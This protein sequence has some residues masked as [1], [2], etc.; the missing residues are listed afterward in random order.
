M[1]SPTGSRLFV[2]VPVYNRREI[3][4]ACVAALL[5]QTRVP[6]EVIVADGGSSDGTPDAIKT[7]FPV[8]T[9]LECGPD[10]FWGEAMASGIEHVLSQQPSA[11]DVLVMMNDDTEF[12]ADYLQIIEKTC[13]ERNAGVG[14]VIVDADD[15][16]RVISSGV[17]IN[18]QSYSFPAS[19]DPIPPGAFREVDALPGRGS[20]VLI[21]MVRAVGNVDGAEFPHYLADYDF[22]CRIRRA[23]FRLGVTGDTWVA[24]NT[25]LTG[26]SGHRTPRGLRAAWRLASSRRSMD[27]L[28]DHLRFIARHTPSTAL[29]IK[30]QS[31]VLARLGAL[32]FPKSLVNKASV[33]W[34]RPT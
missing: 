15:R 20:A 8:V 33:L 5:N 31:I 3:S 19:T 14:P 29:K 16:T 27:N 13:K 32:A 10:R 7:Q 17:T 28:G 12:P 25:R 23:G 22:F 18:W 1:K 4:L 6:D 21:S 11:D 26:L 9:V 24:S 2:V 30:A 34:R